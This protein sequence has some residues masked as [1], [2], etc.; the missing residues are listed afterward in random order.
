MAVREPTTDLKPTAS[1]IGELKVFAFLE[2]VISN[3]TA[4][5]LSLAGVTKIDILD[6]WVKNA[7]KLSSWATAYKKITLCQPSSAASERILKSSFSDNQ[8]LALEDYIQVSLRPVY[9]YFTDKFYYSSGEL[10][11]IV[12]AFRAARYF[13]PVQLSEIKPK[14]AD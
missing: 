10:K 12:L 1:T 9:D 11:D 14:P 13:S 3:L 4:E 6:W 7:D 5:Y 8:N 2:N